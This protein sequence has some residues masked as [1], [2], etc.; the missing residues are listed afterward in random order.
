MSI[1]IT[2]FTAMLEIKKN[3][4]VQTIS[5]LPKHHQWRSN[6]GSF[7]ASVGAD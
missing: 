2:E 5:I 4:K 1:E 3:K 7:G 6:L